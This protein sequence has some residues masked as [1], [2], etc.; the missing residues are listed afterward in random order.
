MTPIT[1]N[2]VMNTNNKVEEQAQG[3]GP[4]SVEVTL[5]LVEKWLKHDLGAAISCLNAI[6]SDPDMLKS[7]ATFMYGRFVNQAHKQTDMF[8]N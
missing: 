4:Q 5:D 6:H 2:C 7:V 1:Y 8:K 3:A